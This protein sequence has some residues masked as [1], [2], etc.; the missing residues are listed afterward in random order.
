[1]NKRYLKLT[2]CSNSDY[3]K[4]L[5][6]IE[7]L[8]DRTSIIDNKTMQIHNY[9]YHDDI[10]I[11]MNYFILKNISFYK[12][13]KIFWDTIALT[14][15][16][17][18]LSLYINENKRSD[19]AIKKDIFALKQCLLSLRSRSDARIFMIISR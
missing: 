13:K 17:K 6:Y 19:C 1:M 8:I 18:L 10:C 16:I 2:N 11:A 15:S 9:F 3:K 14:S 7:F 5:E 12:N 4:C